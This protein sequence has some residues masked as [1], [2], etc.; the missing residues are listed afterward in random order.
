MRTKV[1][2]LLTLLVFKLT[3]YAQQTYQLDVKK[4][5]IL[6]KAPQNMGNRHYGYL[7]FNSGSLNYSPAGAP[8]DGIFS[9]D[10]KSIKT[11]DLSLE[12]ANLLADKRLKSENYFSSTKY[13]AALMKVK[14][15]AKTANPLIFEVTGDLTIKGI[16]N[17]VE[18]TATIKTM[19][20]V[21]NVTANA[22]IDRRKWNID[23]YSNANPWDL[24]SAIQDNFLANQ[25][26]ISL[27]LVFKK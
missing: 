13:P 22:K 24:L 20:D 14:K 6:W 12:A 2:I 17:P 8:V 1:A 18:F 4:S 21:I 19:G 15:I 26:P 25:I 27:N 23:H 11:I 16:T 9:L 7:L 3:A 5:K 10:M